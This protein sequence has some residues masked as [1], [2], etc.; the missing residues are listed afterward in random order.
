M[1]MVDSTADPSATMDLV[2]LEWWVDDLNGVDLDSLL[3][4]S[5]SD[6]PAPLGWA[7]ATPTSPPL[8]AMLTEMAPDTDGACERS[9]AIASGIELELRGLNG[10]GP[11]HI[12]LAPIDFEG[13]VSD[14]GVDG[15]TDDSSDMASEIG[16]SF[17]GGSSRSGSPRLP[18]LSASIKPSPSPPPLVR[19]EHPRPRS[20]EALVAGIS[21]RE[22]ELLLIKH[23]VT[24][25]EH[26]PL[27]KAE[28]RKLR[29]ALRK[30]RNKA[31][32]QRSRRNKE[33]YIRG[34]E[35]RVEECTRINVGLNSKVSRLEKD[36]RSLMQQLN[37]LRRQL[38]HNGGSAG[39]GL[40]LMM[41]VFCV[42][43]QTA[44]IGGPSLGREPL[45]PPPVAFRSRTLL[46][47][48]EIEVDDMAFATA[49]RAVLFAL[50]LT[51]L[52][53]AYL[54]PKRLVLPEPLSWLIPGLA[55]SKG[56][57]EH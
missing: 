36:N 15:D 2:N 55:P 45:G 33:T 14:S 43:L 23:N 16:D 4:A 29:G 6:D 31:S 17:S 48:D 7:A 54:A 8:E 35:S 11:A 34:L 3:P 12:D 5:D 42:S 30:I 19:S 53:V 38:Q 26:L 13:R 20:G 1:A 47:I 46:S 39:A 21:G 24:V 49:A 40:T 10:E 51:A 52:A 56:R 9:S 25:P 57:F 37:D 32:A 50:L 18:K 22:R 44:Q 27:T 28:D 41:A